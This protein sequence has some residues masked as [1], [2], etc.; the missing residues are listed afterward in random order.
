MIMYDA[1]R[2][3]PQSRILETAAVFL[4]LGGFFLIVGRAQ[5]QAGR[6]DERT[7]AVLCGNELVVPL[8]RGKARRVTG[9]LFIVTSIPLLATGA[10]CLLDEVL[11][12]L[13]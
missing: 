12:L 3:L 2:Q 13:R 10:L 7:P 9:L 4:A 6:A 1:A 5:R 11:V 8:S